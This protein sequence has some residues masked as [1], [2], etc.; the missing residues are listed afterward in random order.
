MF[1]I[2]VPKILGGEGA[3]LI[4]LCPDVCSYADTGHRSCTGL[5]FQRTGLWLHYAPK[6]LQMQAR[7]GNL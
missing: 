3:V 4:V 1:L 2:I 6:D 7:G 5:R